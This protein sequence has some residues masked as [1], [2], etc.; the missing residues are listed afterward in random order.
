[1]QGIQRVLWLGLVALLVNGCSDSPTSSDS[2][3]EAAHKQ[4]AA[5]MQSLEAMVQIESGSDDRE[6]VARM[7]DYV[8]S[9]L[10]TLGASVTRIKSTTGS[11][12]IIKGTLSGEGK[13]RVMLIAHTDTV[14]AKGILKTEPLH[15]DGN[16]LYG[17]GIAD[18]KGGVA[19]I[20]HTLAILKA[21][22]WNNYDRITVLFNPD[23]EVGSAGSG[24]VIAREGAEQ[25]VVLS[26]EPSPAKAVAGAEGVLLGAA[27]TA[28][29]FLTVEGRAAHAGS[30]PEQGRNAL[31]ELA[32]QLLQTEKVADDMKDAQLNW[33]T[34]EAGSKRNQIPAH[35]QAGGDVRIFSEEAGQ[36]LLKALQKTVS[37]SKQ[38]ADT[39]TR[40]RLEPGRP[41]YVAGPKGEALA[42]KAQAIY[43]ELDNRKLLLIPHTFGGTDAGYAGRSGKPAV[44][45][46][47]GLAGWGYHARNEYIE[48]DSIVPRLYL[49]SRLLIELGKDYSEAR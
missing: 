43:K 16:R 13:L 47:L 48:I 8:E 26:F 14:Y 49:A 3:E 28:Q 32:Y 34:A 22:G 25:D 45:E 33:T 36:R 9:R 37:E 4:Q 12:D 27:G 24:E 29:A 35:A 17:P 1:M 30:A 40:V 23:E 18:D 5:V 21:Q 46:S 39:T 15:R 10:R 2:L 6:G 44:L 11:A 41:P 38:V 20:L 42:H 7:A 31:L 19:V